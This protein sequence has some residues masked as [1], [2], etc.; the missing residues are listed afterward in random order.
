MDRRQFLNTSAGL[1]LAAVTASLGQNHAL[2]S[3]GPPVKELEPERKKAVE[4]KIREAR[5]VA[6][7]ELA[8]LDDEY[9]QIVLLKIIQSMSL[10]QAADVVG[11]STSLANY[12]LN[13][14]LAE[15]ARRLQ[16]AG[17]V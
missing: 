13:K 8:K 10:R 9:R 15:L 7:R 14:G 12:R 3:D 11:I 6:L 2:V 16:K 17:V 5:D 4:R 1:S